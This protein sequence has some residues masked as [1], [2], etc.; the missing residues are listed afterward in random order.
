MS[1]KKGFTLIELMTVIVLL[2]GILLLIVSTFTKTI[3]NSKEKTYQIQINNLKQA[4]KK[5]AMENP[6]FLSQEESLHLDLDALIEA[7][8]LKN[9]DIV[10]P[11]NNNPMNGC[12][13][14]SYDEAYSQYTYEYEEDEE[15]CNV[16]E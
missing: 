13:I 3:A 7:G 14:I 12:I 5:W 8:Y 9:D 2:A 15:L 11:R 1:P 6:G 10:D 16:S 4:A